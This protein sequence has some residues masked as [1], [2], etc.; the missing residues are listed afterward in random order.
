LAILDFAYGIAL[1]QT[2]GRAV[3]R[4]A[5]ADVLPT[6]SITFADSVGTY[7]REV[8]KLAERHAGRK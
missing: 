4:F 8:S 3:L 1:A 6:R 7:V 2:G 5:N